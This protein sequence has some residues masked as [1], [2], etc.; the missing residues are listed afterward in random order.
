MG[1]QTPARHEGGSVGAAQSGGATR[2]S[3]PGARESEPRA[4]SLPVVRPFIRP[5]RVAPEETERTWRNTTLLLLP[6]E[7]DDDDH[8][9]LDLIIDAHDILFAARME[10][11]DDDGEAVN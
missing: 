4:S 5:K 11:E 2:S 8:D 10:R 3:K 7:N 1:S 6:D 9:E